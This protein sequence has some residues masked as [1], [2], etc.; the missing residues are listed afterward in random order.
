MATWYLQ[1]YVTY[2]HVVQPFV[3]H[4]CK[5][6]TNAAC[7]YK[8]LGHRALPGGGNVSFICLFEMMACV[9]VNSYDHVGT[10]PQFSTPLNLFIGLP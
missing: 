4:S 10:L 3:L 1:C 6:R 2:I 8:N 7:Q 9:P 5:H